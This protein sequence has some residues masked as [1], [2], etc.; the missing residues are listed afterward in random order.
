MASIRIEGKK[1]HLGV[2]D[3]E[4]EAAIAYDKVAKELGYLHYN[5]KD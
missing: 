2:F 1:K 5:F 3:S 4:L